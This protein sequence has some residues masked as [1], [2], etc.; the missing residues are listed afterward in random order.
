M[1]SQESPPFRA[2]HVGSLL[3]PAALLDA[4]QRFARSEID[5]ATLTAA[6]DRAIEAAVRLQERVGLRLATDGEFRRASYHSYFYGQLG[7]IS[8]EA[9]PENAAG[10]RGAQPVAAIRSRIA[11][12]GPIHAADFSFLRMRTKALPKIT[13]PGPSA[14]HFR[15]GDAAVT[16]HAY[17]DVDE[18]WD[19]IVA[20]FRSELRSLATAGCRYVQIDETAFAK[21]GD[22]DVQAALR[23]R[24]DDPNAL[25]DRY[26]DVTNRVLA[27]LPP[28]SIGMHLC[29]GNRG[30]QW[31][32]EGSYEAVAEKLFN[33][34]AIKFFFLEYDS[35][36][37]GD[38]TPLRLVP[39]DKSVVLGLVSTKTGALEDESA[40]KRRIEEASRFVPLE[41][42]AISP[43]CGFASTELGNPIS[44]EMQEAKLRLVVEL[45][46][47]VWGT[48]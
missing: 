2:E 32:A 6:E 4:R 38:F 13:I 18:F 27:G 9:P 5:S 14:L 30:G 48:A 31:H 29:R 35:P 39:K 7:D 17:R 21:F 28:I 11:W 36:R 3:R 25:I 23:A 40:L 24:G 20:A 45:A 34:L 8:F 46:Q 33:R 15:G 10:G 42:L 12:K 26:I 1:R 47:D 43:Q 41:R 16:K 19:D 44:P 37:A 22:A